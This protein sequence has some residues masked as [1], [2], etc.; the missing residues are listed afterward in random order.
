VPAGVSAAI[1]LLGGS[2]PPSWRGDSVTISGADRLWD[3]KPA[4][5]DGV[6]RVWLDQGRPRPEQVE[7]DDE[8]RERL[9][10]LGYAM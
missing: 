3:E 10:A 7:L 1:P 2:S 5:E 8:T 6:L 4:P 9:R